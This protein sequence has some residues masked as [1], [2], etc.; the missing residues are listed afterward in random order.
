MDIDLSYNVDQSYLIAEKF[1]S[2]TKF[3]VVSQ[4]N[5]AFIKNLI[6]SV[7]RHRQ[8]VEYED[9]TLDKLNKFF[10]DIIIGFL[11][12][13]KE[14]YAEYA[15]NVRKDYL[16]IE[17]DEFIKKRHII[18]KRLLDRERIFITDELYEEFEVKA[19]QNMQSEIDK[20]NI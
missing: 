4:E 14:E 1:I 18:L 9:N 13:E 16:W 7:F 15:E 12:S 5:L 6:E 2:D 19:R 8:K 20:S 10:L 11:G 3:S 17:N